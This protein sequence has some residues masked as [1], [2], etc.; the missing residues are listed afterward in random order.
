MIFKILL[1]RNVQTP[2][3]DKTGKFLAHCKHLSAT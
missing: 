2:N 1:S 3:S